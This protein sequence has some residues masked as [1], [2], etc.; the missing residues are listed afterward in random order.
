MFLLK[1]TQKLLLK[2]KLKTK[3][4]MILLV[5]QYTVSFP[6]NTTQWIV[7]VIYQAQ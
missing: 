1:L 4:V 2:G 3:H 5:H 7:A 6:L